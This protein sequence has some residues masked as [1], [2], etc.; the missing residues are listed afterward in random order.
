M[1]VIDIVE[2]MRPFSW[3]YIDVGFRQGREAVLKQFQQELDQEEDS[4]ID[5]SANIQATTTG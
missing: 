3:A 1:N 4:P 5:R 2:Q